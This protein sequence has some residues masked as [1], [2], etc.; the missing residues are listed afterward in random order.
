[1]LWDFFFKATTITPQLLSK[2]LFVSPDGNSVRRGQRK[3]ATMSVITIAVHL[4]FRWLK[5]DVRVGSSIPA[6]AA[7]KLHHPEI[8]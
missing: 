2:S 3:T 4:F 6:V 7:R 5:S 8:P 1:M